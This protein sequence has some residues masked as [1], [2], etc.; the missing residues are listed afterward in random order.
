M[1]ISH[2]N[3][4]ITTRSVFHN[5]K[6][7]HFHNNSYFCKPPILSNEIDTR[8]SWTEKRRKYKK[9]NRT[10]DRRQCNLKVV[11]VYEGSPSRSKAAL[12]T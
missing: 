10:E 2:L 3:V 11:T 12:G 4:F 9:K 7:I 8:R 1:I 6:K 5:H